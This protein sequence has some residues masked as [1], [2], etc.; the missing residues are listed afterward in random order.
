[1]NDLVFIPARAG[2]KG[3]K[4]KNLVKINDKPLIL[5][6][7]DFIKNFPNLMCSFLLMEKKF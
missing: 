4:N 3:I 1:M 6:T 5:H 7:I 2:S